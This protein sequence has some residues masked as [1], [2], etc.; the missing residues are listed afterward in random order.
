MWYLTAYSGWGYI[1]EGM[2]VH[3]RI[4]GRGRPRRDAS[5]IT[6]FRQTLR[7]T[8]FSFSKNTNIETKTS[9]E[10][11]RSYQQQ[12][13]YEDLV[14]LWTSVKSLPQLFKDWCM[15]RNHL[16]LHERWS[17]Q[18]CQGLRL[19]AAKPTET[20]PLNIPYI[21]SLLISCLWAITK[22]HVIRSLYTEGVAHFN[23]GTANA[24]GRSVFTLDS[25]FSFVFFFPAVFISYVISAIS[26]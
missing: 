19:S 21:W 23:Q 12:W 24:K 1:L 3:H 20:K 7:R 25:F 17:S 18:I 8:P 9:K 6:A 13:Y 5:R 11:E 2:P 10:A 4:E 15:K 16:H 26:N 14:T 22:P